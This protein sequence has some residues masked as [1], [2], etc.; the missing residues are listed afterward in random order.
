[1]TSEAS[2]ASTW[3]ETV[4]G[5]EQAWA[6]LRDFYDRLFADLFVG[7]LFAPHD[8]ERLVESQYAWLGAN[9]GRRIAPYRGPSL[10]KSH[11]H[12]PILPGHFDRRH[13]ILRQT[14]EDHGVPEELR[15]E[16]LALD[17]TLRDTILGWGKKAR[18]GSGV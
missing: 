6:L 18:G 8:K 4:G 3:V 5:E 10:R 7:F 16:W 11:A 2:E 14:L 17:R 1:M 12:L 9:L 15:E 13:T